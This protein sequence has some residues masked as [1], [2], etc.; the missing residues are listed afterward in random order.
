MQMGKNTPSGDQLRS[1]VER[2]ELV[3]T[4]KKQLAEDEKAIFAE[5]SAN[6]YSAKRLRDILKIRQ[7][8]PHDRQEAEAELAIYLHAMGMDSEPPLFRQVGLMKVDVAAREQVID[9]FKLLVPDH[10]EIIVKIGSSPVR[11]FR[12]K[13]GEAHAEDYIE[14]RH[15]P[16]PLPDT[17]A[18]GKKARPH[19]EV[20]DVDI[21]GAM[22]LGREAAKAN[23]PVIANPFPFGD[24]R[25]PHWDAGWRLGAGSDGMG[26]DTRGQKPD[27]DGDD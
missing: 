11:L 17:T 21:D 26:P 25:R 8:K 22:L 3:R 18:K 14:P 10:G 16:S 12:D 27:D 24:E 20:P 19:V 13:E 5:A 9:A 1:I 7:M 2:I 4:E 15:E 23:Q 6:G